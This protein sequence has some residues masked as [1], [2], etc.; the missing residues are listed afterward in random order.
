MLAH[1]GFWVPAGPTGIGRP[2]VNRRRH[3]EVAEQDEVLVGEFDHQAHI[4][5]LLGEVIEA[6]SPRAGGRYVDATL[7]AGSYSAAILSAAEGTRVLALDRDRDAIQS[8]SALVERFAERLTLVEGRFGDLGDIAREH[9]FDKIDGAVFDIGVSS[10]QLD[11]PERGFSFRHDGPLDMR[12][13]REGPSAADLVATLSPDELADI[14][15]FYGEERHAGRVA[16]AIVAAREAAPIST[17]RQLRSIIAAAVPAARDGIDPATRSFQALRIAV[18]DELGELVR[19]LAGAS[20]LLK[21][22]GRLA[23][24]TF[25]SLEDRIVKRFLRDLTVP[26]GPLSRHLPAQAAREPSFTSVGGP[27]SPGGAELASNPRARSAKLRFG[28]RGSASLPADVSALLALASLPQ[29]KPGRPR[30]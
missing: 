25:H 24:V 19:G 22:G 11:R 1:H 10:M 14:L 9:G 15:R 8:G 13:S 27:V 7:G 3:I 16:R 28:T 6:L 20:T 29:R 30:R 18:N 21:P 5:V 2:L 26:Q 17:T 23:V 4:P 12:M